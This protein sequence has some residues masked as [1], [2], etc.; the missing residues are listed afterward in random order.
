MVRKRRPDKKSG[1]DM[2]GIARRVR[3]CRKC[4]LHRTRNNA[5]PGEGSSRA[6][7]VLVGEAPGKKED[8]TGRPFV[9]MAGRILEEALDGAGLARRDVF[10]TSILKCRPP[11]NR[12]PEKGEMDACRPYLIAQ[13]ESLKPKVIIALGNYGLQGLVGK[14]YGVSKVRGKKFEVH[15]FPVMPTYHPAACLYNPKLKYLLK[16][17]LEKAK[18]GRNRNI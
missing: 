3:A 6:K 1:L 4:P 17:D 16:R 5:V 18:K 10:I 15:G 13:M 9:G 11:K 8:E 12:N 2:D 7:I 14:R